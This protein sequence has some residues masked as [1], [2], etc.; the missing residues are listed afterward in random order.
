[1][2]IRCGAWHETSAAEGSKIRARDLAV[3]RPEN[4]QIL[5]ASPIGL[6]G[7]RHARR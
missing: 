6:Q 2:T 4:A 1:V 3:A 5:R 7:M